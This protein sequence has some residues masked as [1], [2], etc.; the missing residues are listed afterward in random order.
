MQKNLKAI[1]FKES[2]EFLKEKSK[3]VLEMLTKNHRKLVL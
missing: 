1:V 3:A 2:V